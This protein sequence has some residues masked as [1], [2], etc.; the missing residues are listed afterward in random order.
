MGLFTV[1]LELGRATRG[2]VARVARETREMVERVA[3]TTAIEIE[4]GPKTRETLHHVE[5]DGRGN[6]EGQARS[7]RREVARLRGGARCGT[8]T[9]GRSARRRSST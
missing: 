5:E 9:S 1:E 2:M 3:K 8:S 6:H 7:S 4:L